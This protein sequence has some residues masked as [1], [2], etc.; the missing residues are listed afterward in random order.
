MDFAFLICL[1]TRNTEEPR[2]LSEGKGTSATDPFRKNRRVYN[3]KTIG[4]PHSDTM[5]SL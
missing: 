1:Y 3:N 5:P 2:I 4:E